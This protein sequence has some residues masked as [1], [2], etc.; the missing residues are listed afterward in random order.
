MVTESF[1]PHVN[2]VTNTVR[3]VV[4]HL[5]RHG[6][7]ALVIA[8]GPGPDRY[9]GAPVVRVRAARLPAYRSFRVGLPTLDVDRA[10]DAFGPDLVHLA[11]PVALGAWGLR[12]ARRLGVPTLGVYQTDVAGFVR[13]YG[14]PL[15]GLVDSWVGHLHRRVDRTLAPSSASA[16]QLAGYGVDNVHL[17]RRGVDLDLFGPDRHDPDLHARWADDDRV[18]VGYVGRLA[19]EKNVRRLAEVARIPGVRLVVVGDGPERAWLERHLPDARFT[20]LL[21]GDAL[22]AAF[23]SLDVFVHPGEAETFCQTVQEAQA[24]GVPVVAPTAGGPVDLVDHGRTGL[25]Y[26]V[27]DPRG[28]RR[29]VATLVGDPDLRESAG[30]A[31]A[32]AVRGRTWSAVVDEL[33][34]EHY[35]PLLGTPV[36]AKAA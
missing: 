14:V 19:A 27:A 10:L 28:L 35:L 26:D 25:L 17:W 13:E 36:V 1:L 23:A 33:V 34:R 16:R 2:G 21:T 11:S 30:A 18:V 4:E 29:A 22:A 8:P 5:T 6:H 24:S 7:D 9:A 32:A 15:A 12:A 20:G 31:A 3:H